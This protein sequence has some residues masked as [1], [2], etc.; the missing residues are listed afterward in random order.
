MISV[1]TYIH[2]IQ[3]KTLFNQIIIGFKNIKICVF[4][5]DSFIQ[6]KKI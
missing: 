4:E 1:W 6:T 5:F 3:K 2:M